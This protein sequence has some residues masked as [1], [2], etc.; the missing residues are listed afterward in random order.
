MARI[1]EAQELTDTALRIDPS[2]AAGHILNAKLQLYYWRDRAAARDALEQAQ[3][4]AR[5][6]PEV[7]V[8]WAYLQTIEKSSAKAVAA[9][10]QAHEINPLSSRLN[11]DYGWVHYKARNWVDAE[12]LCRTSVEMDPT[13]SFAL[14]CIIHVNHSQRDHAEAA[15]FGLQLMA[16]RG[17]SEQEIA[18]VR[19]VEDA[20]ERERAYW[21][22][23]LAWASSLDTAPSSYTQRS[24]A[25]AMLG[26]DDDAIDLLHTAFDVNGE[27]FLAFVAVDPRLDSL[28]PHGRFHT[29]AVRAET[30]V[31]GPL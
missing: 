9:I 1:V 17:A 15:E 23:T 30:P 18:D 3:R 4:F 27:P 20:S 26:R 11:A 7:F 10:A 2:L 8:V 28:H 14:D 31:V 16:L 6:D 29:L 21:R 25:L 5:G 19:A 13:S 22:W 24:I 12:R